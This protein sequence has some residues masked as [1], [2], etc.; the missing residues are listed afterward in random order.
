MKRY[1]Q[2]QP[3][4]VSAFEVSEWHH[5]VHSHNHYELIYI[6]KGTGIHHINKMKVTYKPGD[7]FLLGPQ[8]EHY[9]D[10]Q[11]STRF[12]Y[13]KFTDLYI[14]ERRDPMHHAVKEMEYLIH[15]R[16]AHLTGFK[17]TAHDQL[18]TDHIFSLIEILK[19]E[20]GPNERLIWQ[21]VISLSVILKRNLP[22]IIADK[23]AENQMEGLFAY[24][25]ENIYSPEKLRSAVMAVS[26]NTAA[27]Y[28]GPYFKRNAGISLR[29][30]VRSYRHML[31]MKR[32]QS[33][34]Y[35]LK[36]IAA[37]FGLTDE[38]HV[39]KIIKKLPG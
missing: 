18:L 5:P 19:L 1:R 2:F 32:I 35:S 30:Y 12:I 8:E 22:E 29:S 38:S 24:I 20:S 10:I 6:K 26:F 36:Q 25:H 37:E 16:E 15:N 4:L 17:L 39:H 34:N 33:G 21:Q 14:R 31:I 27:N 9:F 23:N 3:V 11:Q 13:L 28:I 7:I